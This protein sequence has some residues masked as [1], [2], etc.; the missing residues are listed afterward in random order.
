MTLEPPTPASAAALPFAFAGHDGGR[1]APV[2]YR[3]LKAW[4]PGTFVENLAVAADGVV[5]VSLHSHSRVE[6][7]DPLSGANAVVAGFP[8]P[9]AGL[10]I[11]AGGTLWVTGGVLGTAPGS[12]WR[13]TDAGTE[14]WMDLPDTVF[15]N[16]ATFHPDGRLLIAESVLGRIIAVDLAIRQATT[17]LT[18]E[19]LTSTEPPTPGANGVKLHDGHVIVSVTSR[20]LV[21]RAAILA[22]GSAGPL[23]PLAARLR[24]DDFA[25]GPDG[26]LFI[27]THP[28]NSVLRLGPDGGRTTLA[29]P[30]EGAVG[31]TAC[32]FGRAPGER[33]ALYVTTTGGMWSP[34]QGQVQPARLLRL[35][36]SGLLP[37]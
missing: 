37:A 1:F 22:D 15:L 25:V 33:Q 28:A 19:C 5:F 14:H 3:V 35:D 24:A 2:P 8:V 32:A 23:T 31:S 7:I 34:Y 11:D 17:W 27:A 20:N 12:V 29:G 18:D 26:A 9:V 21:L 36:L 30:D 13:I 6:R 10:A 16:G 4:A